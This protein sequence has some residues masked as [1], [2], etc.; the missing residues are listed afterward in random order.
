MAGEDDE[1]ERLRSAALRNA[2]A[3]LA[4]RQRAEEEL[5]LA[6]Q[7][8]EKQAKKGFGF[9]KSYEPGW[10]APEAVQE[11]EATHCQGCGPKDVLIECFQCCHRQSY[12]HKHMP[13]M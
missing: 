9:L 6:K 2:G 4:A 3:I 7:A 8:V 1:S 12:K 11:A 5:V 13:S 10:E